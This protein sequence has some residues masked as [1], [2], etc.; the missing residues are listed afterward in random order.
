[1]PI[2][3]PSFRARRDVYPADLWTKCPTCETMVFNKQLDKAHA[4]LP[5]LRPPF[6]A[7]GRDAARPARRSGHLGRARRRSP[8]GRPPRLRRPEVV[9]RPARRGPGGD[10]DA[11]CGRLGHGVD[12]GD[13]GRDLRH[14]LRVHGRIDGRRRRRE[15]HPGRRARA[16]GADPAGRRQRLGRRAHAG[17][18]A[19][20]DAAGQD[21]GCARAAARGRRP[22]PVGA[23][24]SDDRRRVRLVRGRRRRQHRRAERAHR[25]RRVARL[26]RDD[27]PGIAARLPALGIPVRARLHR[28]GRQPARAARRAG[29]AAAPAPGPRRGGRRHPGRPR[30]RD[31]RLPAVLLPARRWPSGSAIAPTARRRPRRRPT[32]RP[33]ATRATTCGRA[34]SSRA[35]SPGRGRSSSSRR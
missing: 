28:P 15:G 35:T 27:R 23:V 17:G 7:V 24:R 21:A 31:A 33:T 25:V 34:S 6:P 8:V 11:R 1:M 4:G 22:V 20:A 2:K 30:H 5:D 9:P 3:L 29:R 13:P 14:G 18:H 10:R 26:G 19:G 12:V 16:R 32:C